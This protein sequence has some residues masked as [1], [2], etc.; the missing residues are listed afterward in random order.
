MDRIARES[1][2][3]LSACTDVTCALEI[4]RVLVV[5]HMVQGTVVKVGETYSVN[6]RMF[7]VET[8][9]TSASVTRYCE[10]CPIDRVMQLTLPQA[11][12]DLAADALSRANSA[13]TR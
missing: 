2:I 7:S 13:L 10:G 12:A 6:I 3:A 8:S 9:R 1:G 11:A 5:D 4:G